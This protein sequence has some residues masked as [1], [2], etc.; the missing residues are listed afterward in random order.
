MTPKAHRPPRNL[1]LE[2]I[3]CIFSEAREFLLNVI[4]LERSGWGRRKGKHKSLKGQTSKHR[5]IERYVF[6]GDH[7]LEGS[8]LSNILKKLI[9]K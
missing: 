4:Y 7:G 6:K 3:Q 2:C 1:P 9:N 5:D 8:S